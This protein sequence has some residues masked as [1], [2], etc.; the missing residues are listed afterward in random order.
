VGERKEDPPPEKNRREDVQVV[1]A[2]RVTEMGR[3]CIEGRPDP[4]CTPTLNAA[5]PACLP[6]LEKYLGDRRRRSR[7]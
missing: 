1:N 2:E 7:G 4:R 3:G 6:L 5:C